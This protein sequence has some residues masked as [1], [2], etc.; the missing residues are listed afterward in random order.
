M[1][2]RRGC[3]QVIR[4]ISCVLVLGVTIAVGA[5]KPYLS[6]GDYAKYVQRLTC[7]VEDPDH[8]D[9]IRVRKL[10]Y[11][12]SGKGRALIAHI[13]EPAKSLSDKARNVYV[14]GAQHGDERNTKI[15]LEYFV[16]ELAT[17]SNDFRN[18]RR[19][20]VIPNY[21]PDGYKRYHRL[22]ASNI[23]LNRDFPSSDGHE[24]APRASETAAFMKLMEKYPAYSMYNIHQP[25]RVVL[26]YPEDES[27]ARP[28]SL[29]SDYP[30][31]TGVGYPTPGSLGTYMREKKVP[32]ITV[33]L[34]R[35]MK[36]AVAPYIYEEI[37]LALYYSAFGCIPK[38][39]QKSRIET[40]IAE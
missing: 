27:F 21:N 40:Y 1:R 16:R 3:T 2:R 14:I 13:V 15:V 31:G 18:R 23:D 19:I 35:H 7:S 28:F 36:A 9:K 33:E 26:Y 5:A 8:D 25:F 39:A 22:N 17:L 29:L 10:R 20:I 37:R 6:A 30:L 34:A 38:P 4:S 12:T 11:G 24:D 32:I